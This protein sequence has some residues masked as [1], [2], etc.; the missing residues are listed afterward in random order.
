MNLKLR[1]NV[2]TISL[3]SSSQIVALKLNRITFPCLAGTVDD[4]PAERWRLENCDTI[5]LRIIFIFDGQL[6]NLREFVCK[7]SE[8]HATCKLRSPD[9]SWLTFLLLRSFSVLIKLEFLFVSQLDGF[10]RQIN[11]QWTFLR[12][13]W[14]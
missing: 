11:R 8:W 10:K 14:R 7:L 13:R 12:E 6:R 2:W 4:F 1:S 9:K 3:D 5:W